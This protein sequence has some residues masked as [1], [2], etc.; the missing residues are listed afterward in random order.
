L[1][2]LFSQIINVTFAGIAKV[3]VAI[4]F[5]NVTIG[6]SGQGVSMLAILATEQSVPIFLQPRFAGSS[7]QGTWIQ[8]RD[9]KRCGRD[10]GLDAKWGKDKYTND[11]RFVV[12]ANSADRSIHPWDRVRSR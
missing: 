7:A 10:S 12:L 6:V 2:G 3:L 4:N 8:G 1:N 5:L 9:L 11:I